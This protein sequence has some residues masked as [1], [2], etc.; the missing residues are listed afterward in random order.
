MNN[1]LKRLGS[2][3]RA[4]FYLTIS[5]VVL[6]YLAPWIFPRITLPDETPWMYAFFFMLSILVHVLFLRASGAKQGMS[7]GYF[8]GTI[9]LRL[10]I[11]IVFISTLIYFNP[12]QTYSVAVL[13]LGLYIIYTIFEFL[14]VF[15]HLRGPSS[16][17][18][19]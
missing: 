16:D 13:F 15:K 12:A 17:S 18:K 2:Y 14:F 19:S 10:L 5:L 7:V 9:V 8:L 4:L 11:S 6:S 3:L 1:R